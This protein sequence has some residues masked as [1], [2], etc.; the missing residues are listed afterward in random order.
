MATADERAGGLPGR[1]LMPSLRRPPVVLALTV[2]YSMVKLLLVQGRSVVGHR[3][4]MVNPQFFR[5]GLISAPDRLG[6]LIREAVRDLGHR[7][8]RVLSAVPGYQCALRLFY[9]PRARGFRPEAVLVREAGRV[10]GVSPATAML[11]WHRL[12]DLLDRTRWLV[13]SAPR[14]AIASVVETARHAGLRFSGLEA[15]P[16]A[17]ARLVNR[18]DAVVAWVG[19]DGSDVVVVRGA[20]PVAYQTLFWGAE[21]VEGE[22]LV[23]RLTEVVELALMGYGQQSQEGPL[24]DDAP[25]F[26]LGTPVG[27]EPWVAEQVADNLRRGL[28]RVEHPFRVPEDFSVHDF[29]VNL[30]LALREV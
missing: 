6:P 9:L 3:L 22:V 21:P 18:P 14:R 13:V 19:P 10:M 16:F 20:L 27:L 5:E 4:L 24:P 30:G 2:E 25:L 23:N 26:V 11:L 17:L 12:P 15:R 1:L 28:G 29:A 7:P 8:R